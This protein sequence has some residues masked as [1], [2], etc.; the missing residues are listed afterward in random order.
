MPAPDADWQALTTGDA[1]ALQRVYE[2]HA[3]PLLR[4]GRQFASP[5]SVEDAVH[6]LFVRLWERHATLDPAANVRPYLFVAV[7]NALLRAT[8]RDAR[9][10][11]LDETRDSPGDDSPNTEDLI[12]IAEAHLD[13][14]TVLARAITQLAPRE[15]EIIRLRFEEGL[16][17]EEITEIMGLSYGAARNTTA[18]AIA[19]LR[20]YLAMLLLG[21]VTS[22]ALTYPL[23]VSALK[24]L[25]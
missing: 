8:T 2:A 10:T 14:T 24:P 23:L 9:T 16:E 20:T 25:S 3:V 18:R 17:Y 19:K 6:D 1:R 5:A 15:R 12:V 7:R 13:Q 11:D 4:Y 22:T 21:M